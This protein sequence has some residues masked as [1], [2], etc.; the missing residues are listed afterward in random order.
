[1][2]ING[3]GDV[4]YTDIELAS[5]VRVDPQVILDNVLMVDPRQYNNA[6]TDMYSDF[7]QA[8]QWIDLPYETAYHDALQNQ[9]HIPQEYADVD[10]AQLLLDRCDGQAELQRMGQE[11]ILFQEYGLFPLLNYLHY[12]VEIFRKNNI[13]VGVG[14]GSSVAS[15]ALYKLGVH[16]INSLYYDLDINEFLKQETSY[17]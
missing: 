9:W 16:K 7:L 8:D 17:V 6:V 15:F 10:I 2:K 1:M 13:V 3:I 4:G 5:M 14:R 12:L 11:L